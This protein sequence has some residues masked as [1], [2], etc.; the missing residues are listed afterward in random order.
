MIWTNDGFVILVTISLSIIKNNSTVKR[1]NMTQ[2]FFY[3]IYVSFL[4]KLLNNMYLYYDKESLMYSCQRFQSHCYWLISVYA[5]K[6]TPR[7]CPVSNINETITIERYTT[8]QPKNATFH[9]NRIVWI[10]L[11]LAVQTFQKRLII[12]FILFFRNVECSIIASTL[13]GY[14]WML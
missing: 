3:L 12:F 9:W 2:T 11:L 4:Y 1:A 6:V 13:H 8:N 10:Y 14:I 5:Q 7:H